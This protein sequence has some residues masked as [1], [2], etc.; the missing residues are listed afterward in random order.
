MVNRVVPLADLMPEAMG[1][2]ERLAE[3][4]RFAMALTKQAFNFVDDLRGKRTAM[5]G[6]FAMH[7]LAHAHNFAVYGSG[8][9]MA[10]PQDVKKSDQG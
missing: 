3:R 2:A 8:V 7:H 5:E 9:A 10:K 4:P 6:V 1:I